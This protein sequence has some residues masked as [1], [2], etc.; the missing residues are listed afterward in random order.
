M[1]SACSPRNPALASSASETRNSRASPRWLAASLVSRPSTMFTRATLSTSQKCDG[2]CSQRTSSAGTA[3][4]STSPASGSTSRPARIHMRVRGRWH[5]EGSFGVGVLPNRLRCGLHGAGEAHVP[6]RPIVSPR[7]RLAPMGPDALDFWLGSWIA[8]WEGGGGTNIV[9][10]ELADA[11]VVERFEAAP[12]EPWSGMSVSVHDPTSERWRQT[13]VDSNGSYWHFVGTRT[14]R[15]HDLRHA[16]TGRRRPVVQAHGLQR[17]DARRVP[18]A[19]GVVARRR[20]RG[21]ERWAIDYRRTG[22][23]SD[24]PSTRG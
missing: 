20:R 21:C 1:A 8:T 2:W 3:S 23:V 14:G 6:A 15:G 12:P 11:V 9:T 22:A 5:R 10:R 24:P 17:R 19:L 13:W 18:L 4:S 7:L 16:G